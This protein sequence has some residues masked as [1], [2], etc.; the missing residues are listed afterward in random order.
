MIH[1]AV[2]GLLA[3]PAKDTVECLEVWTLLKRNGFQLNSLDRVYLALYERER[4]NRVEIG[5]NGKLLVSD[6]EFDPSDPKHLEAIAHHKRVLLI[7]TETVIKNELTGLPPDELEQLLRIRPT[8]PYR[9][10]FIADPNTGPLLTLEDLP[11][12]YRTP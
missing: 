8:V 6:D 11:V 2:G 3:S 10:D 9:G 12:A 5:A 1:F 7:H 4:L